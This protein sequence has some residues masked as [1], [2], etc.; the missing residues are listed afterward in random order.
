MTK[1]AHPPP[2]PKGYP[3]IARRR[4]LAAALVVLALPAPAALAQDTLLTANEIETL[5]A[6]NTASGS[7]DGA[8]YKSF[9][10]EDGVTIY[11]PRG[12]APMRGKWRVNR[13]ENTYESWWD[14]TGWSTY[15]VLRTDTG[16]AW[17]YGSK[18]QPF[19]V[20]AGEHLD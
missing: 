6:G 7:W 19:S 9:F 1:A 2:D 5:L 12:G 10:G 8:A 4:F 3:L 15:Q 18:V 17:V 13:S 14:H 20:Q 16:Y 11:A